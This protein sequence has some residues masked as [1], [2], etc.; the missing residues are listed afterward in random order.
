M[1]HLLFTA[2][3]TLIAHEMYRY[4]TYTPIDNAIVA[5]LG[6]LLLFIV[7]AQLYRMLQPA[8]NSTSFR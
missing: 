8:I 4:S 5:A 2:L 3:I 7:D 1:A 6:V